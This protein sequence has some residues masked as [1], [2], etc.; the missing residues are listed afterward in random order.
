M[1]MC[2]ICGSATFDDAKTCFGCMHPYEEGAAR[3]AVARC[4]QD[5]YPAFV[6][7]LKPNSRPTGEISWACSVRAEQAHGN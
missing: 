4:P 5:E 1:K 7:T 3:T 2:P 6:I